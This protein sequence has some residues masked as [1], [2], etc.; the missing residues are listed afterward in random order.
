M[1]CSDSRSDLNPAE[2]RFFLGEQE[3]LYQNLE[4]I[5]VDYI[6]RKY[7]HD[8]Q[9]NENQWLNISR[10]LN[11]SLNN[12][13]STFASKIKPYYDQFKKDNIYNLQKLLCLSVILSQGSVDLKAKLLFEAFSFDGS[14]ELERSKIGEIFDNIYKIFVKFG[15][16]LLKDNPK[17]L[18]TAQEHEDFLKK[19]KAGKEDL[20]EKLIQGI[21]GDGENVTLEGFIQWFEDPKN[22]HLLT[23][24]GFRKALRKEVS[25]HKTN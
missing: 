12:P 5:K 6:H 17:V 25:K 10:R 20:R 14:K 8:G 21:V 24:T 23:S 18:V 7:S 9:I 19:M 2:E 1:G 13:S 3:L 15:N 16:N 11:L 4:S 22:S